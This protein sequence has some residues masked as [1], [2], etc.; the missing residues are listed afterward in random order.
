MRRL[1]ERIIKKFREL[2]GGVGGITPFQLV[3]GTEIMSVPSTSTYYTQS[4]DI[5][6][7]LYFGLHLQAVSASGSPSL[8]IDMEQSSVRPTT[9]G[10]A[11][12]TY[13][14][15][16]G[17]SAIYSNLNDE[18]WHVK[19][20]TPVPMRYARLKITGLAGNHA[21]DTTLQVKIF[22]QDMVN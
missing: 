22:L 11:D 18:L 9:E 8:Q 14:I 1:F 13:V 5:S 21:T 12:G 17:A 4:V 7:S 15:P 19:S 10:A 3:T 6:K 20:I 2:R 16:D